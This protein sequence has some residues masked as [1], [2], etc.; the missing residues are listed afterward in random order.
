MSL[1]RC[2]KASSDTTKLPDPRGPL[3]TTVPSSS[4]ESA[5][6]RSEA[7]DRNRRE[8][9]S[10]KKRPLWE[11]FSWFQIEKHAAENGYE[12]GRTPSPEFWA[13][14][15]MWQEAGSTRYCGRS[16]SGTAI[17]ENLT[18]KSLKIALLWKLDPSKISRYTVLYHSCSVC[19][20]IYV[21][22]KLTSTTIKFPAIRYYTI[23]V[24]YATV[25][26]SIWSWHV[27]QLLRSH[28]HQ[29]LQIKKHSTCC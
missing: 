23:L 15:R 20:R 26:T 16:S 24:L 25:Y 22:L 28:I 18:A 11:V 27:Q 9:W 7:S 29:P 10:T 21:H 2:F 14:A 17:R 5:N 4:I 3:S 6:S 19:N 12:P 8:F 13:G 1:L